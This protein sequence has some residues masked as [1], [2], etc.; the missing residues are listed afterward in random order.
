MNKIVLK[1]GTALAAVTLAFAAVAADS[2][3]DRSDESF[4]RQAAENG[5]AE[6]EGSK[7]A[8]KNGSDPKVKAFA[9][10][11]VDDHTKAGNELKALA[12]TKGVKVPDE[13][14]LAQK[15]SI[16]VLASQDGAKFDKNYAES[17]GV[18]AH[19]DTVKLF[20]KAAADAKDADVKAFA[21]KTLPALEHHLQMAKDLHATTEKTA[22]AQ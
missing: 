14:S 3:L 15:A 11:M 12:D 19:E 17:I 2:K 6:V 22:K 8:L 13:P 20:K 21:T 5:H 18:K 1:C 16:K 7:V 9:Q 4:L 10:K